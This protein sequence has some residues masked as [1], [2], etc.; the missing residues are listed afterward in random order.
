M[1][2][3]DYNKKENIKNIMHIGHE[4]LIIFAEY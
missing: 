4:F 2:N 3:F 1:I